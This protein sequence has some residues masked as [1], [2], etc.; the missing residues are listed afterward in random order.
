MVKLIKGGTV[1]NADGCKR[2]DVLIEDEVIACVGERPVNVDEVIDASG[3][4]V[5]PGFIDT[6]THFDLDLGTVTTADDF[7]TGTLSALLGGTTTVLDFATQERG[8]TLEQ[9]LAAWHKK[10]L[11][12]ACN[13]GFHMAIAS[14][15]ERTF[16]EMETMSRLGV[17]SY[18]MYMVY[19]GLRMDDGS[20]YSAMK[21]AND[22]GAIIGMHCENWDV[23]KKMI[24][25]VKQAGVTKAYGHPLS[26]PD[27][28]EAEAIARYMRI[29]ELAKAPSYVVHLSTREGLYEANRARS[30]G[31]KVYLETCPQYLILTDDCYLE[32]DGAKFVMSPP[33]RKKEDNDALWD[34]IKNHEIDFIGTDHCSFTMEQKDLGR[35]DFS[36]IPNGSAGVQDRARL[37]FTYGVKKGCL[38]LEDMAGLLSENAARL[39]GMY[40]KRGVIKEGSVA[41]IVV[42]DPKSTG[43]ISF[44]TNAHNCDNSPYEGICYAG[45]AKHVLLGGIHAVKDTTAVV[46]NAGSFIIRDRCGFYR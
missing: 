29:A 26:R 27:T 40:P 33:L 8:G 41:D 45:T 30:R 18:K 13:Y 25:E 17:T 7:K 23:L 14:W 5:F 4:Y 42:W 3:C 10:A 9:A 35:E 11:G 24:D 1:V 37:I 32:P 44:R 36:K 21:R 31:Q 16:K 6:H 2:A 28:V 46:K 43:R 39:F 15:N 12:S 20:I 34:A 38:T 19:E 22:V